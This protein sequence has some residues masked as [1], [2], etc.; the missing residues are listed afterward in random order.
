MRKS[1]SMLIGILVGWAA[2]PHL[3]SLGE[4]LIGEVR[5]RITQTSTTACP[6]PVPVLTACQRA[7]DGGTFPRERL[8]RQLCEVES[9]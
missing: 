6:D 7:L 1:L 3:T 4:L 8:C 2:A 9:E 5:S